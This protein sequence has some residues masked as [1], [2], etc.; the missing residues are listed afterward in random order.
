[1]DAIKEHQRLLI[2]QQEETGNGAARDHHSQRLHSRRLSSSGSSRRSSVLLPHRRK[3]SS[4]DDDE[5]EM[6]ITRPWTPTSAIGSERWSRRSSMASEIHVGG[7]GGPT[8]G[9]SVMSSRRSS[10]KSASVIDL[11]GMTRTNSP[12]PTHSDD[13][14]DG[15]SAALKPEVVVTQVTRTR[16]TSPA[17]E[18]EEDNN[19][20]RPVEGSADF[21][22]W[23]LLPVSA[24]MTF[25]RR[26]YDRLTVFTGPNSDPLRRQ[27]ARSIEPEQRRQSQVFYRSSRNYSGGRDVAGGLH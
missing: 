6:G 22:L 1:V 17:A 8:A 7:A 25:P 15:I 26:S 11:E 24:M 27:D 23:N 4:G 16:S 21:K 5:Q 12:G 18:G 13:P 20:L 3:A 14:L 2:E 10:L 9:H 19:R